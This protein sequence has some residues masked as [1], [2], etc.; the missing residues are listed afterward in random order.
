MKYNKLHFLIYEPS[1][2]LNH[3]YLDVTVNKAS[4][5]F[6]DTILLKFLCFFV[7][8]LHKN[9]YEISLWK[10]GDDPCDE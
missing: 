3:V 5:F 7:T 9:G 10:K 8:A 1:K 4:E 6:Q 2:G